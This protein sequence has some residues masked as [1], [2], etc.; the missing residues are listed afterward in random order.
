MDIEL[1]VLCDAAT[2]S[3]GKLNLLGAFDSILVRNIPAIHPQ[4][5][6]ALRMRFYRAE[7]GE[8]GVRVTVID[9]DGAP[10]VPDLNAK[11]NIVFRGPESSLAANMILN[12][13][14][15]QFK[16]AGD[17]L[18]NLTLD[19]KFERAIPLTVRL[20]QQAPAKETN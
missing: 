14:R 16:T 20:M 15:V 4:C 10:V 3:A 13:Q 8:H 11:L 9:A 1:F 6:V 18:I 19:G 7:A 17:Y 5:A 12:L 2:E